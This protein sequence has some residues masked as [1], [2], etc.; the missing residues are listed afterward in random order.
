[1][2]NVAVAIVPE[3]SVTGDTD[4]RVYLVN[5][6]ED[7]IDGVLISSKGYGS[8]N[9]KNV[10]TSMLRQFIEHLDA[11]QY[12]E[13]EWID[14]KLFGINNEFWVSFWWRGTLYDKRFIFVTE[15]VAEQ[16][17]T[18]IPVLGKRGVMIR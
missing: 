16:N 3:E 7:P 14:E 5:L 2:E 10:K 6:K 1:M 18:Q 15:S 4:W 8:I 13:I 12:I 11:K 9:G 17:F